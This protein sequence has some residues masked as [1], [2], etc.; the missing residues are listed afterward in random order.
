MRLK[1][2]FFK[3]N[4]FSRNDLPRA[5]D[6][7]SARSGGAAARDQLRHVAAAAPSARGAA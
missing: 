6:G 2:F 7:G 3:K 1:K 5:A 4:H